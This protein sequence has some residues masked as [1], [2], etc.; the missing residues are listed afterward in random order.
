[1]GRAV[2]VAMTCDRCGTAYEDKEIDLLDKDSKEL[3]D[4][5]KEG[6]SEVPAYDAK[7]GKETVK[8]D[9]LCGPCENRLAGL[10]KEAG[11]V[12]RR[13]HTRK[14]TKTQTTT[15]D[16]GNGKGKDAGAEAK[17]DGAGE[18]KPPKPAKAPSKPKAPPTAPA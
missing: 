18:A 10:F 16:G 3:V 14:T 1:M 6:L 15:D 4:E 13:G 2:T 12:K 5:T 8:Y 11:P 17:P 7:M 9:D